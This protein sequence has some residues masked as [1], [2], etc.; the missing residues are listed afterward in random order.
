[1]PSYLA[2]AIASAVSGSAWQNEVNAGLPDSSA[3]IT[4]LRRGSSAMLPPSWFR[5]TAASV[6]FPTVSRMQCSATRVA[7]RG[8]LLIRD[9][10]KHRALARQAPSLGRSRVCSAPPSGPRYA[11]PEAAALRPG[12]TRTD[13]PGIDP[14]I[15]L[16]KEDGLPG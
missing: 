11:R 1:M 3:R 13:R 12:H 14:R 9:R 10:H 2:T 4:L 5:R 16:L 15:H 7:R 8:A 6:A